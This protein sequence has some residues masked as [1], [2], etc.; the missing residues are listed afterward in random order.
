[1]SVGVSISAPADP[2]DESLRGHWNPDLTGGGGDA[3]RGSASADDSLA[4]APPSRSPLTSGRGPTLPRLARANFTHGSPRDP[5]PRPDAATD[6]PVL[7][8]RPGEAIG[9]FRLVAGLG[10]GAFARVYL[11]HEAVLGNRPIALK[12][13]RADGDEPNLLARLQAAEPRALRARLDHWPLPGPRAVAA[14]GDGPPRV[15]PG[16]R[17]FRPRRRDRARAGP[18]RRPRRPGVGPLPV[19]PEVSARPRRSGAP[20]R[21]STPS[22]SAP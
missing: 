9:G 7:I 16:G 14:L 21:P 19:R 5:T 17:R 1:M 6:R 10:R 3:P 8:P 4:W 2:E 11:A 22:N 15:R 13:S 20:R 18:G 12:V